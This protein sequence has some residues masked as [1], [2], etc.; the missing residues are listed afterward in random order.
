MDGTV[1]DDPFQEPCKA[2]Q[3]SETC[4]YIV[5]DKDGFRCAKHN[6]VLAAQ[7]NARVL[8]GVMTAVGDNCE[9]KRP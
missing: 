3:K 4:R 7:I 5:F 2:G 1:I 9:G 6:D 8:M